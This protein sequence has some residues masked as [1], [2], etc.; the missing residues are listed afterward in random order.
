M[1]VESVSR[2]SRC[3]VMRVLRAVCSNRFVPVCAF[4]YV[5]VSG[6][7]ADGCG[8]ATLRASDQ[9]MR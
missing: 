4:E 3:S 5:H 9:T 7:H 2:I 6:I 1:N 8:T